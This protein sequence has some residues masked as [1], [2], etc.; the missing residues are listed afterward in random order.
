MSQTVLDLYI[1]YATEGGE[2]EKTIFCHWYFHDKH[3]H[4]IELHDLI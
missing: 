2:E 3:V 4:S 1:H